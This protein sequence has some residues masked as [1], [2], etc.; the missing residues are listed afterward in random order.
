MKKLILSIALFYVF[1]EGTVN[2]QYSNNSFISVNSNFYSIADWGK[3]LNDTDKSTLK[4]NGIEIHE[5]IDG[6]RY[7]ISCNNIQSLSI[8]ESSLKLQALSRKEKLSATLLRGDYCNNGVIQSLSVQ[9]LPLIP[10]EYILQECKKNNLKVHSFNEQYRLLYIDVEDSNLTKILELEFIQYVSCKAQPGEPEDREGRNLHR[11]NLINGDKSGINLDGEGVKALVRDDGPVGPHIDF[12]SRLDNRTFGSDGTHGDGVGGIIGGAGNVDPLM[13]GMAPRCSV[14]VV[15]YQDDFLDNTL[16]LHQKEGVVVTNSSYSNGCNA[17]YTYI[18]QIVDK[19]GYENPSL[20]HC[21]SAGNSNN[22]NCNYGAGN[23]WGN[24]TGGHKI[25]KNVITA[26]NLNIAGL[27][28]SSSSR[29]PT[30]DGRMKPDVSARGTNQNSTDPNNLYQVFGGTSAA[31]PGVAGTSVLLYQAYKKVNNGNNPNAALIKSTLMNTATDLG[32]EGPD[33]I[34]GYGVIDGL[35]AYNLIN[36]KRYKELVIKNQENLEVEIDVPSNIAVAKFMIYWAEKEASLNARKVLINDIDLE[37]IAPDGSLILPWVLNP[38]ADSASLA[39][40]ARPGIDTLN[41][42][43]Q[44][45]IKFPAAGK[46]KIII[47]GK[48]LPNINVPTYLLYD[49]IEN[50]LEIT[51]PVGGELFST[52]E[53]TNIYYRSYQS[54][55]IKIEFSTDGGNSWS[56]IKSVLGTTRLTT[57][58]TKNNINSDKCIIRLTQ[59]NIISQSGLFTISNPITGLK[60]DQFCPDKV[61]LNWSKSSK[62]SFIVYALRGPSMIEVAR[63]DTNFAEIPVISKSDPLWYA[64]AGY[65]E[66]VL[67]RRTKAIGAPDTL[68]RCIVANDLSIRP[69]NDWMQIRYFVS[70]ENQDFIF[71]E[72]WVTNRN[73]NEVKD[74]QIQFKIGN[75]IITEKIV[76][77]LKYKDSVLIKLNNGIPLNFDGLVKIPIWTNLISDEFNAN[78]TTNIEISNSIVANKAGVFPLIEGFDTGVIPTDWIVQSSVPASWSFTDQI[79]KQGVSSKVLS[80]RNINYSYGSQYLNLVSK[81]I[82][83]AS[84]IEPFYYMD[85]AYHKSTSYPFN[86]D[87][88]S[89]EVLDVCTG[90]STSRLL[91]SGAENSLYTATP[92]ALEN[93]IPTAVKDWKTFAIDLA[94]FKGRKI[95]IRINL[96]LGVFSN[97]YIDNFKVIEKL[98]GTPILTFN[99]NPT[100]ACANSIVKFTGSVDPIVSQLNWNFGTSA[101][102]RTLT[103]TGPHNVRFNSAGKKTIVLT[104]VV[105]DQNIISSKEVSIYLLPQISFDFVISNQKSVQFTNFSTNIKDVNWDFGDGTTSTDV[106]PSHDFTEL[107]KYTVTLTITN[108]CGTNKLIREVDLTPVYVKDVDADKSIQIMP[109]PS[110]DYFIIKSVED[111]SEIKVY[112]MDGKMINIISLKANLKEY[113]LN[114]SS[115]SRAIY[116]LKIKT[117]TME[118]NRK[119]ILE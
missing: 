70:C 25:A 98:A 63:V 62:D 2:A 28:E 99:W 3:L 107:K 31:S 106:N 68:T 22:A 18:T 16:E 92:V 75:L 87:T 71:P 110:S 118:Y 119:V 34:Y 94:Q 89:L 67:G 113:K 82:D 13:E 51:S 56:N 47:K 61:R 79:N 55:S 78:D 90:V 93:W 116:L 7:L 37:V 64:V 8:V 69:K 27:I 97:L 17:G 112:T 100:E 88:L 84:A 12:N 101:A 11:V 24:I 1:L 96:K 41:N 108:P 52:L 102:P 81:T 80:Q 111:L 91:F 42:F 86:Y 23:Q 48:F 53:S 6:T 33:Y 30:R 29:G 9:F 59:G 58:T 10:L 50:K 109:N 20:L 54:D 15:N 36:E 19:Q 45:A 74:F 76:R 72:V 114:L 60:I 4:S 104:T 95:V 40:G 77:T 35:R 65:R 21:F 57:W 26:A 117:T 38:T 44:V 39:S 66:G 43:E 85:Y 14:Y 73:V 46:Y 83:L 115:Y 105:G 103:G 49:F 5:Y 32:V